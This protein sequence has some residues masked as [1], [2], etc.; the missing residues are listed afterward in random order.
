[1]TLSPSRPCGL[2]VVVDSDTLTEGRESPARDLLAYGDEVRL[3][4]NKTAA[5][6]AR[7]VA[8]IVL[9]SSVSDRLS[10]VLYF[11]RGDR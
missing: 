4:A 10:G 11:C 9:A 6:G 5:A 3:M 1:M 8:G 2:C 7:R